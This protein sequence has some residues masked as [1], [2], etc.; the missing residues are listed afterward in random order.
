MWQTTTDGAPDLLTKRSKFADPRPVFGG[1]W[2]YRSTFYRKVDEGS[3]CIA[4]IGNKFMDMDE[5]FSTRP[6]ISTDLSDVDILTYT[7]C[8]G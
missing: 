6:E 8:C 2:S 1:L 4:E 5:P 3:W 7:K